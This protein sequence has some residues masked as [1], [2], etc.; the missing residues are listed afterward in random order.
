M[1]RMFKG[2][3][4]LNILQNLPLQ[5]ATALLTLSQ[6]ENMWLF[7]PSHA[8]LLDFKITARLSLWPLYASFKTASAFGKP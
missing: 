3:M 5:T 7:R 4:C 6:R 8:V 1:Y 2:K